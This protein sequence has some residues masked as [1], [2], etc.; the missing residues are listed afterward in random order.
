MLLTSEYKD[1]QKQLHES[2]VSYG[3]S[4]TI[5]KSQ[6]SGLIDFFKP[7]GVLDYGCGKGRAADFITKPLALYDPCIAGR[8]SPPKPS[9]MVICTDVLEHIEPDCLV[10][11]LDH[12]KD[13]TLRLGFFA[14][15]TG[16]ALKILNDGRNAH[17]IQ[18]DFRWWLP[19]LWERFDILSYNQSGAGFY[20]I[21]V[22]RG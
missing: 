22:P 9:A 7:A 20:V 21:V 8:D 11:V 10:S 3:T 1:Q 15:H 14:I 6:I 4:S 13:L 18:E 12:L 2:N 5:Y 16:P 17:L 19:K